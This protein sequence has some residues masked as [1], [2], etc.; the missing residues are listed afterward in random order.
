MDFQ[1]FNP[2]IHNCVEVAKLVAKSTDYH[3]L[4]YSSSSNLMD[5]LSKNIADNQLNFENIHI[6]TKQ[7][8]YQGIII[9]SYKKKSNSLFNDLKF[10]LTLK[11][12]QFFQ[13]LY[14][15][16]IENEIKMTDHD[17]YLDLIYIEPDFRNKGIGTKS[18]NYLIELVK[19][20]SKKQILLHVDRA[21]LSARSFYEKLGFKYMMNNSGESK[22]NHLAM[23]YNI[24]A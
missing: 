8:M 1:K 9:F 3:N 16:L 5:S 18:I 20:Q 24:K 21:N 6:L 2:D 14:I 22:N 12:N 4:T 15:F 11:L 7:S 23:S 19:L 10:L 13:R 17:V